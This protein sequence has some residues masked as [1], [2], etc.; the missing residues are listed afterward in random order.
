MKYL[1]IDIGASGG[2]AFLG[3]I[4]QNSFNIKEL[5]RFGNSII[6]ING[7]LHW[8]IL[9]LYQEVI[10]CIASAPYVESIGIDTWAVDYGY[11]GANNDIL[12]IPFAYRDS[13]TER[14]I[15]KVHETISFKELYSITG[16]QFLPFNT[17]YQITEDLVSRPWLVENAKTLLMIPELLSFLISGHETA[18][19][20]NASTTGLLDVHSKCW[21][22][23]IVTKIGFPKSKLPQVSQPGSTVTGLSK[24]VREQTGCHATV[25]I[26]ACHDTAC[27]VAAIPSDTSDW[28]FISSG[29][30]SLVGIESDRP[31]L[32]DAAREE[33]FTNEGG[34]NNKIRFL[35]NVTGFWILDELIKSWAKNGIQL[36]IEELTEEAANAPEC[37]FHI[38]PDHEYFRSPENMLNAIRNYCAD[39]GHKAPEKPGTVARLVFE[40]L[41]HAYRI[42]VDA[43]R[44]LADKPINYIHI[45]GGG[46]QNELLCQMTSNVCGLPVV[47]GPVNATGI[48]NIIMQAVSKGELE[49][50]CEARKLIAKHVEPKFYSPK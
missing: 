48:G 16:I 2:K 8:D 25:T 42:K 20:T 41:A 11:I 1:A 38:D 47:A 46:A 30:W 22:E 6:N 45:V 33:N 4:V 29:T 17:I 32:S 10:T 13:R 28:A 14:S 44:R 24:T 34:V 12:G 35:S 26:G 9:R 5:R 15:A 27:A 37:K 49:S 50:V 21:S 19:Y 39:F 3:E 40:S 43:I 36:S 7:H 31:I 23:E 18:E